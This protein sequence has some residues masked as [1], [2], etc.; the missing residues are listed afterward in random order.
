[1]RFTELI[2]PEIWV[3]SMLANVYFGILRNEGITRYEIPKRRMTMRALVL[4]DDYW[5][6]ASTPRAGLQ[7]LRDCDF[8]F[9]WVENTKEW[10]PDSLYDYPLVVF[11]KSDN[12]TAADQSSWVSDAVQEAFVS[13]VCAGNGLLVVHSGTVY[14]DVPVMRR[15]IG[16]A[17]L[18][19]PK[20]CPVT[21]EP[22]SGHLLTAGSSS[23]TAVD[24]HYMMAFDDENADVFMTTTSEHGSQP[25]GWT[26]REGA[27]RVCVLTP[28]HNVEVWQHPSYLVLLCNAMRWCTDTL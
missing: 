18:D 11:T 1:M 12:V 13:Y 3:V 16:G 2:L 19:H 26:R 14:K 25:G 4:C 28:G 17:F 5:H 22:K 21:I 10:S 15:L 24:E 9:D 7:I 20:Q 27:G 8:E 23:F 6:P